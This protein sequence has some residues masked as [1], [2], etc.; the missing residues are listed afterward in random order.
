[1]DR[2]LDSGSLGCKGAR[3]PKQDVKNVA[4]ERTK[5]NQNVFGNPR[6]DS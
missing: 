5:Y 4:E 1:M 2:M 6:R 3:K